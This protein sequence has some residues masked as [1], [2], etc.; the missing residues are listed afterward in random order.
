[1][2]VDDSFT[3]V[4][5]HMDGADGSQTFTDESGKTWTANG[6]ASV[7]TAQSVFGDAG[8]YFNGTNSYITTPDHADF[9]LGSGDFTIDSW[10]RPAA[11]NARMYVI[12][13]INS[14]GGISSQAFEIRLGLNGGGTA[15]NG[16]ISGAIF[17][18]GTAYRC[19]SSGSVL[20]ANSWYHIALVRNGTALT[21]YVGGTSQG[22]MANVSGITVT[23][24]AQVETIGRWGNR[25]EYYYNGWMDEFRFSKGTAHWTANFT[26]PA[27]AYAPPLILSSA[28]CIII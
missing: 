3:K 18:G 25:N 14:A 24:P 9:A 5:L 10:I 6:N 28:Q 17:T 27:S 8:G 22:V 2:A 20:A 26:P 1:M 16:A 15:Q 21:F 23:D 7:G 13:Q 11:I 12:A 4:L 19:G